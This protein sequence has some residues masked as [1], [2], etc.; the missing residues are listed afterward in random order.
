MLVAAAAS[1]RNRLGSGRSSGTARSRLG[2]SSR[3]GGFLQ[4]GIP[5]IDDGWRMMIPEML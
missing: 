4:T 5:A 1:D 2:L 3:L